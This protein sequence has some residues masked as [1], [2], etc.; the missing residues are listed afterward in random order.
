MFAHASV[1]T[2]FLCFV[3]SSVLIRN[4][5]YQTWSLSQSRRHKWSFRADVSHT[6][7][8]PPIHLRSQFAEICERSIKQTEKFPGWE[9]TK[10]NDLHPNTEPGSSRRSCFDISSPILLV[11]KVMRR[12]LAGLVG[13]EGRQSLGEEWGF[14]P[15]V[16]LA[17]EQRVELTHVLCSG[18]SRTLLTALLAESS[19]YGWK[20]SKVLLTLQSWLLFRSQ[21]GTLG[22]LKGLQEHKSISPRWWPWWT[23]VSL[24]LNWTRVKTWLSEEHLKVFRSC[25]GLLLPLWTDTCVLTAFLRTS[26][27]K[28]NAAQGLLIYIRA[29]VSPEMFSCCWFEVLLLS[30]REVKWFCFPLAALYWMDSSV[31]SWLFFACSFIQ[32]NSCLQAAWHA[33]S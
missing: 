2:F 5:K 27:S 13:T 12:Q 33:V 22:D 21:R 11:S 15:Q 14:P 18:L 1:C 20:Q 31:S 9:T 29:L 24:R 6:S 26:C 7:E 28:N 25:H 16:R 4:P 23:P 32:L 8:L 17:Q 19:P 3:I 30:W 10:E